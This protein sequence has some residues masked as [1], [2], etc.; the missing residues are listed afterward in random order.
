MEKLQRMKQLLK[1]KKMTDQQHKNEVLKA[2]KNEVRR[3]EKEKRKHEQALKK[4]TRKIEQQKPKVLKKA[5]DSPAKKIDSGS[6]PSRKV[7]KPKGKYSPQQNT[8]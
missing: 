6:Q 4:A 5:S 2:A 8:I 7:V 1:Q 3:Q